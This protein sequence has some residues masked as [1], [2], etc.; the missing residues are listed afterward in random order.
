[1]SSLSYP[2]WYLDPSN[3]L[4]DDGVLSAGLKFRKT[5]CPRETRWSSQLNCMSCLQPYKDVFGAMSTV[6]LEWVRRNLSKQQ[7]KLLK[8]ACSNL[9]P[10]KDTI[11]AWEGKNEPTIDRVVERL[12]INYTILDDFIIVVNDTLVF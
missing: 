5:K 3:N 10:L 4:I 8:G 2:S 6:S 11:L 12:Y 7:W 9:K 1:M